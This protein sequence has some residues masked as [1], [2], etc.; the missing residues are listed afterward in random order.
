MSQKKPKVAKLQMKP[1]TVSTGFST[2]SYDPKS[3]NVGYTLSD[4]LAQMRDIFYSGAQDF[5]PSQEQTDYATGMNQYAM[6]LFGEATNR[7]LQQQTSDYY[8]QQQA[9]LA[10]ERERESARL[11][12]SMFASGRTGYGE[13]TGG[14]YINPQQYALAMAREN[15]NAQLF[16]GAEDRSRA[17]QQQDIAQ[18]LGLGDASSALMMR[19][20]DQA[21]GLFGLGTNIEG[22]GMG[23]LNTVGQFAPLQQQ[24]QSAQQQNQQAINNAKSSGGFM[25]GL[26]GTLLNAGLN[27]ASGGLF[28]GVQA[29][30]GGNPFQAIGSSIGS[31]LGGLFGS[32]AT[33]AGFS[34]LSGSAYTPTGGP[35]VRLY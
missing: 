15:Q 24:W 3:G 29:A 10:P 13:G 14:G 6:N 33:G 34:P 35:G 26:G 27:Y 7:N 12:D 25:S 11:A 23:V 20:Y 16:Q 2:G 17:F 32:G 22:M 9:I 30:M 19:P 18:A 4:P 28:S 8:N 5:L 31:S 1:T 21:A